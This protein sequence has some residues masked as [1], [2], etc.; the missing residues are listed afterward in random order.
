MKISARN[1]LNGAIVEIV[2]GSTT[3]HVTLDVGGAIVTSAITDA[4]VDELTLA[5]GRQ[6]MLW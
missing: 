1:Q 2:K 6:P 3:A 4:A 5:V